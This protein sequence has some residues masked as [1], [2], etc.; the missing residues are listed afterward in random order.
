[1]INTTAPTDAPSAIAIVRPLLAGWFSAGELAAELESRLKLRL[2]LRLELEGG[3][4]MFDSEVVSVLDGD[5]NEDKVI[6]DAVPI[7]DPMVNR[8]I[9]SIPGQQLRLC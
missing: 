9:A 4:S 7:F 5:A 3:K 1:M 2:E 6:D 8:L